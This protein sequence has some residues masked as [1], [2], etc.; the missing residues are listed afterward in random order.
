M[1]TNSKSITAHIAKL[2]A[3]AP[4]VTPEQLDMLRLHFPNPTG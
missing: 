3:E 2:V 1:D 4:P